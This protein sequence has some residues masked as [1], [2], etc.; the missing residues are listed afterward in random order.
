MNA[1]YPLKFQPIFKEKIWGGKKLQTLFNKNIDTDNT[2]ESWEISA[3]PHNISRV[4]NGNLAGQSLTAL[5][6]KYGEELLGQSIFEKYGTNF[7]LL[8]KFID[9]KEN[10]SL[11]V[12]PNDE[13]AQ[14]RHN[15]FGKTEMWYIM[16]ADENSGI[17]V[18]FKEGVGKKDYLKHLK[19]GDL[20]AIMNFENVSAGDVFFI[21]TGLV[22]AIGKGVL[23][24]EI[25]QSSDVTYRV[26]DW[27]R[28]DARGNSRE[29]H[30]DLAL[31]AIDYDFRDFKVDYDQS[32]NT[33]KRLVK[34]P[35]FK[36]RKIEIKGEQSVN[37]SQ[38]DSFVVIMCV[39]GQIQTET[40]SHS[41]TLK[42]GETLLLPA[43]FNN[44]N[45]KTETAEILEVSL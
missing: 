18:G 20:Q 16:Q 41:E 13:I 29:L 14:K 25:Q 19:Q 23:L 24:A 40:Q 42:A 4:S 30:T 33:W 3:I 43:C 17:Y 6:K 21:K 45:F 27:N 5:I 12:H 34:T 28:T 10:L 26:F 22:H 32:P 7:P 11:Q 38:N 8:F 44:L 31:D 37:Y 35:Y 1:L 36:T 2:G 39:K 15:S 9:A